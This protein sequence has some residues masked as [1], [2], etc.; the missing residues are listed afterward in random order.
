MLST[1]EMFLDS[2]FNLRTSLARL[3]EM[4]VSTGA[5]TE[6]MQ[7]SEVPHATRTLNSLDAEL[8]V[9]RSNLFLRYSVVTRVVTDTF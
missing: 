5:A 3:N 6:S 4:L 8:S 2:R 7:Q 9:S 1:V